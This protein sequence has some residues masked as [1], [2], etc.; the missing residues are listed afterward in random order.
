MTSGGNDKSLAGP[1]KGDDARAERLRMALR[2]NLRRRKAQ[3]KGRS[4][5]RAQPG[6]DAPA[7]DSAGFMPDKS[8]D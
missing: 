4:T 8:R 2:E 5:G 6:D 7:H 3:A 1:R